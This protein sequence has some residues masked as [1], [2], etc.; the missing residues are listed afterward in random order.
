MDI[1]LIVAR[2]NVHPKYNKGQ[3]VQDLKLIGRVYPLDER[4]GRFDENW[5]SHVETR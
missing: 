5:P 1:Y 4:R 3:L 2:A